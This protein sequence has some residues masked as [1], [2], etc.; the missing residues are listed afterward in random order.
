MD[1]LRYANRR[2]A[3]RL[4]G[5]SIA[6]SLSGCISPFGSGQTE[7]ESQIET[8]RGA[9]EKYTDHT[10]ALEDGFVIGGPFVPGMGWHFSHPGRL[11]EAAEN[12]FALDKP[13]LLVYDSEMTLGAA[14]WAAP[15]QAVDGTPDLFAD[16][17]AEATENW[18]PHTAATHVLAVPDGKQTE[19]QNIP[20][21]Q[22]LE[23]SNWAEFRPPDPDL[24][25]GDTISLH[26]GSLEAKQGSL[27]E[28]RTADLVQTHPDLTTL[29]AWVHADN[30]EGMFV[31]VNPDFSQS[32]GHGD[33]SH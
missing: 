9:T 24:Q 19:P 20:P 18:H 11:Q 7:F 4:T 29:H 2:T 14:E 6:L 23:N 5:A 15:T 8:V 26:W 32:M 22:F 10:K 21:D 12:G 31:P 17:S 27:K 13:Q 28:S 30:P 33:H 16:D 25:P 3:L 1:E